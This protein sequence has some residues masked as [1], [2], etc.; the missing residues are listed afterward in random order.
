MNNV[1]ETT[2]STI[3]LI[4]LNRME[5]KFIVVLKIRNQINIRLLITRWKRTKFSLSFS[6]KPFNKGMAVKRINC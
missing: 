5:K 1:Y 6:A 3:Q 2:N 4:K